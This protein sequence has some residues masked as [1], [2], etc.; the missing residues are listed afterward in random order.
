MWTRDSS[1]RH[2]QPSRVPDMCVSTYIC[3]S[4]C[5]YVNLY[6]C[7]YVY[8]YVS[9][10]VCMS[11]CCMY[12][13]THVYM[14]VSTSSDPLNACTTVFWTFM[15]AQTCFQSVCARAVHKHRHNLVCAWK[16]FASINLLVSKVE[17]KK[18]KKISKHRAF[19]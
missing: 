17:I 12:V 2:R 18:I 11:M 5:L 3:M 10:Y 1:D 19:C 4:T 9:T 14:D 16:Y 6:V 13:S 15:H 8:M 7:T